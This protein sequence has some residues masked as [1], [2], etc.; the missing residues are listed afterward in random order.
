MTQWHFDTI[1]CIFALF[2]N[3]LSVKNGHCTSCETSKS[4]Y[5]FKEN[6]DALQRYKIIQSKK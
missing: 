2:R 5:K 4:N 6:G 1:S 3:N